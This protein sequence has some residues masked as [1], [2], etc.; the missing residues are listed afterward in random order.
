MMIYLFLISK[1]NTLKSF[2]SIIVVNNDF[3][4]NDLTKPI[5]ELFSETS[6]EK[7]ILELF[8]VIL[9]LF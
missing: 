7:L 9:F 3:K 8:K 5:I 1:E 4:M 6:Y 2:L